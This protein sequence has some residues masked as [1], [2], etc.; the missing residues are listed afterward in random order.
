[1]PCRAV[2]HEN[3]PPNQP[4]QNVP[5]HP[6]PSTYHYRRKHALLPLPTH[7]PS[8]PPACLASLCCPLG[9]PPTYPPTHSA[10]RSQTKKP[11]CLLRHHGQPSLSSFLFSLFSFSFF[12]FPSFTA[13]SSYRVLHR[14]T[15][16][17]SCRVVGGLC[18]GCTCLPAYF[19]PFLCGSPFCFDSIR[20]VVCTTF[21][22]FFLFFSRLDASCPI[23]SLRKGQVGRWVG[24]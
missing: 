10:G 9:I 4:K 11:T 17:V 15:C 3:R 2:H 22:S 6:S 16:V 20:F 23:A 24:R 7:H 21:L 19:F 18:V 12:D 8:V 5:T 1:M 14:A 13:P